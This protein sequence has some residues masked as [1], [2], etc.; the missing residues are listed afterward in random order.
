MGQ[1]AGSRDS[2]KEQRQ[3]D[4]AA[5]QKLHDRL[6]LPQKLKKSIKNGGPDSKESVR[7]ALLI[8]ESEKED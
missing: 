8:A 6:S 1:Y 4:A 2:S 3:K 7:L 5:R